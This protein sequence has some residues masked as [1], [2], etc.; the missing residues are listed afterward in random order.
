MSKRH[1]VEK[2]LYF[3]P[4]FVVVA[5]FMILITLTVLGNFD[6]FEPYLYPLHL[7]QGKIVPYGGTIAMGHYPHA[8]ELKKLKRERGIE[9]DISLLNPE[10]PQ[11]KALNAHLEKVA[12]ELG[13]E[14]RC[15]PLGYLDIDGPRN[16][17]VMAELVAFIKE[18]RSKKVYIHCYLGRHRVSAVRN[19]LIRQGLI[20]EN[21]R[22]GGE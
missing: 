8:H 19:E 1:L 6:I 2:I 12:R 21:V 22:S 10:L 20:A 9:M 5:L 16:K 4:R 14:L 15:F 17:K 3:A 11:E 18:N 7:A 13:I